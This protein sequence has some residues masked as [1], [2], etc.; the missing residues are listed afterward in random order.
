VVSGRELTKLCATFVLV[1]VLT[2]A[3]GFT[4]AAWFAL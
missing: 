2:L 1:A 4:L 3:V